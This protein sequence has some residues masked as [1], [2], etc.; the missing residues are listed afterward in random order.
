[1]SSG[2]ETLCCSP[3]SFLFPRCRFLWRVE[4]LVRKNSR[5]LRPYTFPKGRN[6]ANF[7]A[8]SAC[9]PYTALGASRGLYAGEKGHFGFLSGCLARVPQGRQGRSGRVASPIWSPLLGGHPDSWKAAALVNPR[10][11]SRAGYVR[12]S[13]STPHRLTSRQPG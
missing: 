2:F 13:A 4:S 11:N 12:A 8:P 7:C 5:K 3:N 1:M 10:V 6:L 9:L